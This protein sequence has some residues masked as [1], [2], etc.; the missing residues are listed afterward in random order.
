MKRSADAGSPS[1]A[2]RAEEHSSERIGLKDFIKRNTHFFILNLGIAGLFFS[3]AVITNYMA[4][5]AR[6]VGGSTEQIGRILSFMALLEIPTMLFFVKIHKHISSRTIIKISSIGFTGKMVVCWLAGSVGML[7]AAML[8][9][10]IGFSLIM[11][12][13][14]YYVE[15]IMDP[16]EVIKGQALFTMMLTL[17]TIVA[18]VLGGWLIDA[19]GVGLLNLI[20]VF[21]TV[22]GAV[23]VFLSIDKVE[24]HRRLPQD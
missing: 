22:A 12:G 3:N 7:Y 15:E 5:I 11:P 14:V 21:V 18:S 13:M 8:F 1:A 19:Y 4:Q 2:D 6:N 20:S 23:I 10:L 24:D 17:S 16:G 9:Q